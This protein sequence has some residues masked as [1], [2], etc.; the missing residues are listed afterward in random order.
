[1]R[2]QEQPDRGGTRNQPG[3]NHGPTAYVI[4]ERASEKQRDQ[5]DDDKHGEQQGQRDGGEPELLL[6]HPVQRRGR[7]VRHER[8]V[9]D[10]GH[11]A[12]SHAFGQDESSLRF[13]AD[14]LVVPGVALRPRVAHL[15]VPP[16]VRSVCSL[17]YS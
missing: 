1:V 3:E 7:T 16:P 12:E 13:P 10:G 15:P 6:I 2:E 14:C 4:R 11:R 5:Q 8:Q 9:R 17:N